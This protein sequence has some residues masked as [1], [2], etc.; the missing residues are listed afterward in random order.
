MYF[1]SSEFQKCALNNDT[2]D[3][4][5]FTFLCLKFLCFHSSLLIFVFLVFVHSLS[6]PIVH[7]SSTFIPSFSRPMNSHKLYIFV[8]VS[9]QFWL[10]I[11]FYFSIRSTFFSYDLNVNFFCYS[12]F[13]KEVGTSKQIWKRTI[14]CCYRDFF[15]TCFFSLSLQCIDFCSISLSFDCWLAAVVDR[16]EMKCLWHIKYFLIFLCTNFFF[17]ALLCM[18]RER[19]F[20]CSRHRQICSF[21]KFVFFFR[22]FMFHVCG[23]W[24]VSGWSG[25]AFY[26]LFNL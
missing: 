11:F 16:N 19:L 9:I 24:V 5:F 22:L 12:V 26:G 7:E 10:A 4:T 23:Q 25:I 17:L 1:D 14:I 3:D 18:F 2:S 6:F 20:K 13:G 8:D 15:C 21:H